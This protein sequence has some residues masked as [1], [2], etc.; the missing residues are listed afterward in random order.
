MIDL[1]LKVKQILEID[2]YLDGLFKGKAL[3]VVA[4]GD[5]S[6][7]NY[8]TTCQ[9]RNR[10]VFSLIIASED[11]LKDNESSIEVDVYQCHIYKNGH[12]E[13]GLD[14]NL[15]EL[16]H[17]LL[18]KTEDSSYMLLE[19]TSY[20]EFIPDYDM[21]SCDDDNTGGVSDEEVPF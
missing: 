15:V 20:L 9:C 12:N 1:S 8:F 13:N 10:D 2:N 7:I 3:D 18:I 11:K 14:V 17:G 4:A 16:L 21:Y 19:P 6:R 5:V